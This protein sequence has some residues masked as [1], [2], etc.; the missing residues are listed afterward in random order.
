[1]KHTLYLALFAVAMFVFAAAMPA[2]N[3]IITKEGK[4]AVVNTTTLTANVKGFRGPTPVKLY[5]RKNKIV[6]V[7]ALQNKETPNFFNRAKTLL[8]QYEGKSVSKAVTMKVDAVS[9]AT[10]SSRALIKNVQAGAKYY[11][12]H[13]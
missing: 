13:K 9:G 5:I 3:T 8:K 10:F 6:K 7:E 1:M 11:K 12:E 2:S 4:T